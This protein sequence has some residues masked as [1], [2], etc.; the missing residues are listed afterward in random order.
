M[1]L[2]FENDNMISHTKFLGILAASTSEM[3]RGYA[4][5]TFFILKRNVLVKYTPTNIQCCTV[6]CL[7]LSEHSPAIC[8]TRMGMD[9]LAYSVS[10]YLSV[11]ELSV[12]WR[13]SFSQ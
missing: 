7:T 4:D 9:R 6:A 1:S 5:F 10:T 12:T 13:N 3:A 2:H 11:S 8:H